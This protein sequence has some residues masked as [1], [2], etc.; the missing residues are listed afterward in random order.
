MLPKRRIYYICAGEVPICSKFR[1]CC[2]NG[3][4]CKYTRHRKYSKNFKHKYVTQ[5]V[6]RERFKEAVFEG[7]FYEIEPD[8][9]LTIDDWLKE[10]EALANAKRL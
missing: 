5:K 3:G 8:N 6:L 1:E 2:F 7:A 4:K 9:Q 10:K